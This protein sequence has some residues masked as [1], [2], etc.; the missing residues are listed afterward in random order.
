M[1]L[2]VNFVIIYDGKY[3]IGPPNII[4]IKSTKRETLKIQPIIINKDE[5]YNVVT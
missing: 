5:K 2:I 1:R 3:N 4:I